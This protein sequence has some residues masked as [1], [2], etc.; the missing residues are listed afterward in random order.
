MWRK[1]SEAFFVFS[2]P[3]V[4]RIISSLFSLYNHPST[5]IS[6]SITVR[7]SFSIT[8][9]TI[10]LNLQLVHTR[11]ELVRK[12]K[13][14]ILQHTAASSTEIVQ[15]AWLCRTTNTRRANIFS[16]IGLLVNL[17]LH[18]HLIVFQLGWKYFLH[19]SLSTLLNYRPALKPGHD[20]WPGDLDSNPGHTWMWPG[21][22]NCGTR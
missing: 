21:L 6:S 9:S 7:I 2:P 16:I 14:A 17:C 22:V 1:I 4:E 18:A 12:G 19:Y 8:V 5:I 13:F 10:I 11:S 20:C 3:S 15:Q